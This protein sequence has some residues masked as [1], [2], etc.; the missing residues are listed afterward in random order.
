MS[1][2]I[3]AAAPGTGCRLTEGGEQLEF[4]VAAYRINEEGMTQVLLAGPDRP[5]E[6]IRLGEL[7][8]L[9]RPD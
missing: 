3:A 9:S 2:T 1:W 6:W 4:P 7:E 8:M 5:P